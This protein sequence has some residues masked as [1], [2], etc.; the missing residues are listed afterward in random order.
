MRAAVC[1]LLFAACSG[2]AAQSATPVGLWRTYSDRTGQ[3]DG[4]VRIT[5]ANGE[6]E[7]TVAEVFSPPAPNAHPLCEACRGELHNQPIVG[8]KILRRMRPDGDAYS[9]G[10]ILDPDEGRVYRCTLR[11]T[12]DGRKLEVRGYV[13]ISLFGRTQVW[14]RVD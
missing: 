12:E 2:A 9:G 4:L 1:A 11:M 6:L 7:G 3:A 8:M 10:E 14:D 5:T 13:G